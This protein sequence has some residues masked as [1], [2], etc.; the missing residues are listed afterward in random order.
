MTT[1]KSS[2]A[3]CKSSSSNYCAGTDK[4]SYRAA[5]LP[6]ESEPNVWPLIF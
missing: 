1:S 5:S 3:R 4:L 2:K 6:K